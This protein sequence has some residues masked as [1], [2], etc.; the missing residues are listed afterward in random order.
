MGARGPKTVG[1]KLHE[2]AGVEVGRVERVHIVVQ[3][4]CQV[5]FGLSQAVPFG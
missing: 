4:K 2:G 3:G 1:H 5:T